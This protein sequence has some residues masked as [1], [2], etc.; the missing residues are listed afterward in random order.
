MELPL[1]CLV[2]SHFCPHM[3]FQRFTGPGQMK[4]AADSW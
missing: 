2:W 4:L 3:G 1:F